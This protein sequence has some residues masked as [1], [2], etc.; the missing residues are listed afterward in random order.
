[1]ARNT[2]GMSKCF[3]MSHLITRKTIKLHSANFRISRHHLEV[4]L[5]NDC[6]D[7]KIVC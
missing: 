7:L 6:L 1:M 4:R 3:V 2:D 5:R